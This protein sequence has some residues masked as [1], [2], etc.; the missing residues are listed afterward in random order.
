[1]RRGPVSS[2]PRWYSVVAAPPLPGGAGPHFPIMC[3]EQLPSGPICQQQ[4]PVNLAGSNRC[5]SH[6]ELAWVSP[7][8]RLSSSKYRM[9][10]DCEH[11]L[12]NALQCVAQFPVSMVRYRPADPV[13]LFRL[14]SDTYVTG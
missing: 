4:L 12:M 1:M 8:R 7:P 5:P 10:D 2:A 6:V 9:S 11:S 14:S 13:R 3:P